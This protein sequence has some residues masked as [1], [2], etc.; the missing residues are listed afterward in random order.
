MDSAS[1]IAPKKI[2]VL[3]IHWGFSIGGVREYALLLEDVSRHAPVAIQ[4]LLIL[5]KNWDYDKKKIK[6]LNANIIAINSRFD[7]SWVIPVAK[8]FKELQP[9]LI[10]T[11]GFNGHAIA[12]VAKLF[13]ISKDNFVCTYHGSYHATTYFRKLLQPLFNLFTEYFI[14]NYALSCATVSLFTK[15]YLIKKRVAKDKIEIIHNGLHSVESGSFSRGQ[16]RKKWGVLEDEILV[17]VT[18]RLDP[19]KGISYILKAFKR[20]EKLQINLKLVIIGSGS[21]LKNL[22]SLSSKLGLTKTVLYAGYRSDIDRCLEALD[23]YVLPSLFEY[24]SIALLEAM[25]AGKAII[26]TGVGGNTESVRDQKEALI[27]PPADVD[28]LAEAIIKLAMDS[29]LRTKLGNAAKARFVKKF[30]ADI[31]AKKT[32]DWVMQCAKIAENFR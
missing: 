15:R 16:L 21:D 28:R 12:L 18:S 24:H 29:V 32:A 8:F 25:R 31:M 1:L 5:G 11:H 14:R 9:D 17:G 19:V 10:L 20:I 13:N 3:S 30:T 23:I 22:K 26:A 27:V 4:S 7:F 2:D 6:R